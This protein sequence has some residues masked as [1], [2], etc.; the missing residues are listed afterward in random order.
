M[1]V[2]RSFARRAS[3]LFL[4]ST[5]FVGTGAYAQDTAS[6]QQAAATPRK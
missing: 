4:A 3:G 5:A 6:Q 1:T 2:S